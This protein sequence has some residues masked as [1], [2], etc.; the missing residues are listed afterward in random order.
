MKFQALSQSDWLR[1]LNSFFEKTLRPFLFK[2]RLYIG[3]EGAEH[4]QVFPTSSGDN[5]KLCKT[6]VKTP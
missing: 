5:I 4:Q 6:H 2:T 3:Y 1:G